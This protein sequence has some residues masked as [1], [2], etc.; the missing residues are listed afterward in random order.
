M[1]SPFVVV[2]MS[3]VAIVVLSLF[4][5][6]A[7]GVAVYYFFPFSH[8]PHL[9]HGR[10]TWPTTGDT[11]MTLNID[12]SGRGTLHVGANVMTFMF[13]NEGGMWTYTATSE[14]TTSRPF[15]MRN[16]TANSFE[17]ADLGQGDPATGDVYMTIERIV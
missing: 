14:G 5:A 17:M 1:V 7:I 13:N 2:N 16:V 10:W 12:E 8:T 11:P 3:V 4:L 9:L 6:V 15:P